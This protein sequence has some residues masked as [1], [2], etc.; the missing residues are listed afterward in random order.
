MNRKN[1]TQ[2]LQQLST[3]QPLDAIFCG[4]SPQYAFKLLKLA[5]EG[6]RVALLLPND[7]TREDQWVMTTL[8][9]LGIGEMRASAANLKF[10]TRLQKYIPHLIWQQRVLVCRKAGN[11]RQLR[12]LFNWF[13]SSGPVDRVERM[14]LATIKNASTLY[15]A[16]YCEGLLAREFRINQSRLLIEVVKEAAKR[17]A[18]IETHVQFTHISATEVHL[19]GKEKRA[20]QVIKATKVYPTIKPLPHAKPTESVMQ[21][22]APYRITDSG[23]RTY[24]KHK[25]QVFCQ[26]GANQFEW[27]D[28][29]DIA[30]LPSKWLCWSHDGGHVSE[31][32]EL[33]DRLFEEAQQTGIERAWFSRLFYQFGT[34][35]EEITELAYMGMSET[36]DPQLL[37][38]KALNKFSQ[39]A[40]WK[41]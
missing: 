21:F 37:W 29:E 14:N 13:V 28:K 2:S 39:S 18:M 41:K 17:G 38:Q 40:E 34:Q 23:D 8:F 20:P 25:N 15:D 6:K 31:L 3:N 26:E 10:L 24:W 36:R 7:F 16:G 35:I 1:R 4:I 30:L 5:A 11:F 32:S 19:S 33:G 22:A 27:P 12:Q 9:P